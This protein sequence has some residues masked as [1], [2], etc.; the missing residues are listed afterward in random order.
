MNQRL[1]QAEPVDTKVP[2]DTM[3]PLEQMDTV[4]ARGRRELPLGWGQEQLQ[5]ARDPRRS[6]E[7]SDACD[8]Q[9]IAG[10]S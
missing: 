2:V 7:G 10:L 6:A 1:A 5:G 8:R 3:G 4:A 9:W